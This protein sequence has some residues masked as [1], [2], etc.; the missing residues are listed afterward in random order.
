MEWP[1]SRSNKLLVTAIGSAALLL[2]AGCMEKRPVGPQQGQSAMNQAY[3]VTA[4]NGRAP[5]APVGRGNRYEIRM[6]DTGISFA[7]GC[8]NMAIAGSVVDGVFQASDQSG[9]IVTGTGTCGIPADQQWEP[10]LQRSL[11]AGEVRVSRSG[12]RVTLTAPDLVIEGRS[13]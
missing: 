2:L 1:L 7:L 3:A 9:G 5:A 6:L 13:R 12:E 10:R 11:L 8:S 4:I